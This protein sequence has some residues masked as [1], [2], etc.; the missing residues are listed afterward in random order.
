[1]RRLH[2]HACQTWLWASYMGFRLTLVDNLLETGQVSSQTA[3]VSGLGVSK[4]VPITF[5]FATNPGPVTVG[6]VLYKSYLYVQKPPQCA[7]CGR[8]G[9]VAKAIRLPSS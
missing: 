6:Y 9:H 7:T 1:M 2:N 3:R 4:T 5:A 8:P